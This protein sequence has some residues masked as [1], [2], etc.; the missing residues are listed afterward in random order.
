MTREQRKAWEKGQRRDRIVDRAQEI[1]FEKGFDGATIDDIAAAA[2]YSKRSIYLYFR[3]R[4]ELFL[5]VV[6]RG[7]EL[8]FD[9]LSRAM[10]AKGPHDPGLMVLAKAFFDFSLSHPE[11]FVMIMTYESRIHPYRGDG[12]VE[13]ADS[14]RARCRELSNRYGALVIRAIEDDTRSGYIRTSLE[15]LQLMLLL[16]GQVFGVMQI[17]L[18]RERGFLE[19]YGISPDALFV[20][21]LSMLEKG[22]GNGGGFK[23]QKRR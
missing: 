11:F 18:M 1:F 9:T 2:G 15:P 16:W 20:E 8:L 5:A 3:D 13:S 19:T 21:F 6:V 12:P 14:A 7:Q 10:E 22:L 23:T 4:E 17:I